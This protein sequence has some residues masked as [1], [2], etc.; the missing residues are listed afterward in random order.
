MAEVDERSRPRPTGRPRQP[1]MCVY[2]LPKTRAL[3]ERLHAATGRTRAAIIASALESYA[4]HFPE[5]PER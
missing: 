1:R 5:A 2:M 4:I 3:L